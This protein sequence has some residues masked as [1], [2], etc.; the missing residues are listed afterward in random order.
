MT[1]DTLHW[2]DRYPAFRASFG[3]SEEAVAHF[4][5]LHALGRVGTAEEVA[6]TVAFLSSNAASFVT[7]ANI[8]VD[9]GMRIK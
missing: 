7:G 3:T 9:G 2:Y 5:T 6:R 1:G 8:A 4:G